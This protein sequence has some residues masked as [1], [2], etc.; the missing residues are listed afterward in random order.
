MVVLDTALRQ[1]NVPTALRGVPVEYRVGPASR[2]VDHG[3]Y[4]QFSHVAQAAG[5]RPYAPAHFKARSDGAGGW[6]FDWVR[7]SRVDGDTW[8]LPDVPIGEAYEA[9]HLRVLSGGEVVREASTS[10]PGWIYSAAEMAADGVTS[11]DV[12]VAQVSDLYGPGQFTRIVI[13]A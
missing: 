1:L 4:V 5:L 13:N 10:A 2:P 6:T 3:A 12:E 7:R 9:Y 8:A 11:F